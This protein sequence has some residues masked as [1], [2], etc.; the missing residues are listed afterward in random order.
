MDIPFGMAGFRDGFL[1]SFLRANGRRP[2][3]PKMAGQVKLGP[4][5][6]SA[7]PTAAPPTGGVNGGPNV[8]RTK[9]LNTN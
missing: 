1:I 2:I 3:V 6:R 4:W 9:H 8:S 7:E 5:K